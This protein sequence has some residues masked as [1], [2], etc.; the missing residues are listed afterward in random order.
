ME[1]FDVDVNVLLKAMACLLSRQAHSLLLYKLAQTTKCCLHR[2]AQANARKYSGCD[3][4]MTYA[5]QHFA[6]RRVPIDE[7]DFNANL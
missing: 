4:C 3:V 6:K 1:Y 2:V 5:M 7:V